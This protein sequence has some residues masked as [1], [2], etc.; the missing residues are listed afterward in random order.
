MATR[1]GPM[2]KTMVP[3]YLKGDWQQIEDALAAGQIDRA[4]LL[5]RAFCC[6]SEELLEKMRPEFGRMFQREELAAHRE[7]LY[8]TY[9]EEGGFPLRRPGYRTHIVSNNARRFRHMHDEKGRVV[10]VCELSKSGKPQKPLL[11]LDPDR[12]RGMLLAGDLEDYYSDG[13]ASASSRLADGP[14]TAVMSY[15]AW[16]QSYLKKLR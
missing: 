7:T 15:D 1:A 4:V 13:K 14:L 2:I 3:A 11:R 12:R 9:M 5:L 10:E 16:V 8:A 6:S